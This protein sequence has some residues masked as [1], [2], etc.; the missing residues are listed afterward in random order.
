MAMPDRNGGLAAVRL[1][2]V[3]I[4]KRRMYGRYV[5]DAAIKAMN[6]IAAVEFAAELHRAVEEPSDTIYWV[7]REEALRVCG[8]VRS[9]IS[10][11]VRE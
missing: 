9:E 2:D 7:P 6:P 8:F 11:A 3:P 4:K 1:T 10:H 5:L